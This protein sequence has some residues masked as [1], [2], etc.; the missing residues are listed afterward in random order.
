MN[1]IRQFLV[2]IMSRFRGAEAARLHPGELL[3][4]QS[5]NPQ[6]AQEAHARLHEILHL[7]IPIKEL[8]HDEFIR[9]W[10]A[11]AYIAPAL[12]PDE[13]GTEDGGWPESWEPV[14]AEALRRYQM[15][16]LTKDEFYPRPGRVL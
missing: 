13:A 7:K 11:I 14:A 3:S 4:G 9:G 6:S 5:L 8:G 15:K 1:P 16:K 10:I 12:D 2:E